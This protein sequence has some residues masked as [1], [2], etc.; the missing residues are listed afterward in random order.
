MK[1]SPNVS[2]ICANLTDLPK[3]KVLLSNPSMQVICIEIMWM[4]LWLELTPNICMDAAVAFSR[5]Q[6][7]HA[8]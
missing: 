7:V 3:R 1:L 6:V 2:E 5:A 4:W 8:H